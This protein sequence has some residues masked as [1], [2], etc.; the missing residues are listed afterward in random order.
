MWR[1]S[2]SGEIRDKNLTFIELE[3]YF[4]LDIHPVIPREV[5]FFGSVYFGHPDTKI[6]QFINKP[7]DF[8]NLRKTDLGFQG[9]M[10]RYVHLVPRACWPA[11]LGEMICKLNRN[12]LFPYN[13]Y[14]KDPWDWY[15]YLHEWLIFMV[16]AGKYTIVPWMLWVTFICHGL[17]Q[18]SLKA[19]CTASSTSVQVLDG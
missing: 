9:L 16:N 7:I 8:R 12:F 17:S 1:V 11:K 19:L 2:F 14:P 18:P 5:R 15:I 13:P 10:R 4:I 6:R 3:K